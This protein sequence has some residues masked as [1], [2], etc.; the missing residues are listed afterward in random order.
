MNKHLSETCRKIERF[1]IPSAL[2][3][4]LGAASVDPVDVFLLIV[5]IDPIGATVAGGTVYL[6]MLKYICDRLEDSDLAQ[7]ELDDYES[8]A[9]EKEKRR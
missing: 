4:I 5:D 7:S 3:A 8:S 1:E 2:L 9:K 6:S